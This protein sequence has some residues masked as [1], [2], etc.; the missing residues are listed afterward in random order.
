LAIAGRAEDEVA[1]DGRGECGVVM[2]TGERRSRSSRS[3]RLAGHEVG[4]HV[5]LVDERDGW[6]DG[7]TRQIT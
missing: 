6:I 1:A 2:V 7:A 5:V 3:M 4:H